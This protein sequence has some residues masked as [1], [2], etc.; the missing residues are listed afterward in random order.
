MVW[1]SDGLLLRP[2]L[3]SIALI[4]KN[5]LILANILQQKSFESDNIEE[6]LQMQ[7]CEQ[8]KKSSFVSFKGALHNF[9]RVYK[10]RH[11]A[12]DTRNGSF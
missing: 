3:C 4:L 8:S 5:G 2:V 1:T 9:L 10:Q 11:R 7:K 12:L 6:I